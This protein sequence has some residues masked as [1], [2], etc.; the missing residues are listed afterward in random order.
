M[1]RT[2]SQQDVSWFL[3]LN[4]KDQLDLEPPIPRQDRRQLHGGRNIDATGPGR[5]LVRK[6]TRLARSVKIE[7]SRSALT[8][9]GIPAA[10]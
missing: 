9:L 2:I 4:E 5:G 10:S 7:R 6:T 3:D 1:V 8:R